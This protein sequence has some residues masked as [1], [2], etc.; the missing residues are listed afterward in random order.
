MLMYSLPIM[1]CLLALVTA[2]SVAGVVIYVRGWMVWSDSSSKPCD[3]P[4]RWWLLAMLLV[5]IVQCRLNQIP[6][7][8]KKLQALIM[9]S[10]IL[11]GVVM[12]WRCKTCARTNPDLFAYARLYLIFQSVVWAATMFITFSVVSVVFWMHRHGLLETGPGPARAARS[13]LI[14]DMQTVPYSAELFCENVTG[15]EEG[16]PSECS[17][18]QEPF[19]AEKTIKRTPC[20]HYFHEACLQ[21]W[22]EKFA[23]SCPLCRTNLEEAVEPCVGP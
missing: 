16:T 18:C 11:V 20:D 4:L 23:K 8:P 22:L 15:E 6:Q 2:L 1:G 3:Q 17:I 7:R 9:P 21:E 14:Q 13:G 12:F 10:V 19:D 5:P